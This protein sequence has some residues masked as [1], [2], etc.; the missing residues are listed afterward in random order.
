MDW[1]AFDDKA[2]LIIKGSKALCKS[3]PIFPAVI[4]SNSGAM[5]VPISDALL[6]NLQ[7]YANVGCESKD[8]K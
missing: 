1:P 4:N 3:P 5:I 8:L 7:Q 2:I 6:T